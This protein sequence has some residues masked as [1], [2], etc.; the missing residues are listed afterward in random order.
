MYIY[1]CTDI[2]RNIIIEINIINKYN[3]LVVSQSYLG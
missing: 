3:I 2:K 1:V